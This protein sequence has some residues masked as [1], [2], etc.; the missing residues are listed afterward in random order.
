MHGHGLGT[1]H[2]GATRTFG[3]QSF[4]GRRRWRGR[5]KLGCHVPYQ[6]KFSRLQGYGADGEGDEDEEL[7]G[8]GAGGDRRGGQGE[9]DCR[10]GAHGGHEDGRAL[11]RRSPA[12]CRGLRQEG[13]L[14]RREVQGRDPGVDEERGGV[15]GRGG[16]RVGFAALGPRPARRAH[17]PGYFCSPR[18]RR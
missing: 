5:R 10:G 4:F 3:M 7:H 14:R 6:A 18:R 13:L 9:H 15:S 1:V 17:F 12:T 16:R 8:R 11:Y 2:D